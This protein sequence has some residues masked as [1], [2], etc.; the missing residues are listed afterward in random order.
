MDK[1]PANLSVKIVLVTPT[2]AEA[3]LGKNKNFRPER[4][5]YFQRM[6]HDMKSG[7][8]DLNGETIKLD[9]KG[10]LRDG[11]HRLMACVEAGKPFWS[12][13]VFGVGSDLNVDAGISRRLSDWLS[14]NGVDHYTQ[15]LS[16]ALRNLYCLR[17]F[18]KL[19]AKSEDRATLTELV[20]LWEKEKG[21]YEFCH[22]AYSGSKGL[23]P[24]GI[25]TALFY[26]FD[27]KDP[28]HFQS[29]VQGL[30]GKDVLA[31]DDPPVLL[32]RR[33]LDNRSQK[34]KLNANQIAA[35]TIIAWNHWRLDQ[36]VKYLKWQESGRG[37]QGF[38]EI[39]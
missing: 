33:L 19:R 7:R 34:T 25:A 24:A 22:V 13:V 3:W 8:W 23:I 15:T 1:P 37:A 21:L 26:L 14:H 16:A 17:K 12:V 5:T 10:C 11:Q 9:S 32:H 35:L 29:F 4:F 28:E 2:T 18:G 20:Q 30:S 39:E 38:P 31:T 6:V 36:K 27:E